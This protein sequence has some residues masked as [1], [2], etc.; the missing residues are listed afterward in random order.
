ML[1]AILLAMCCFVVVVILALCITVREHSARLRMIERQ[2]EP[3]P[4]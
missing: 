3:F 1:R 2:M 4:K